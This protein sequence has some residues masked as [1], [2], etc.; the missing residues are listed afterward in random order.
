MKIDRKKI[1][2]AIGAIAISG[3]LGIG[4]IL[5]NKTPTDSQN[6]SV[7]TVTPAPTPSSTIIPI[8]TVKP[9]AKP[10]PTIKP[11]GTPTPTKTPTKVPKPT[12]TP[13][14]IQTP[15]ILDVIET[16]YVP[17]NTLK[18]FGISDKN[19]IAATYEIKK[20]D[21]S[22]SEFT[23]NVPEKLSADMFEL[24]LN[25]QY[26]DKQLLPVGKIIAP[27]LVFTDTKLLEIH[28]IKLE[29]VIGI[30]RFDDDKLTI[31]L[32]EGI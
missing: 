15:E 13:K 3:S 19:S 25:R 8:P 10:S 24:Y 1:A 21:G 28:I 27:P 31:Y 9:T 14:P 7:A 5:M 2:V 4:G 18:E 12:V 16:P 30:G 26:V 22:R 23:I 17:D 6:Q 11:S 32:K 20:I 29:Q